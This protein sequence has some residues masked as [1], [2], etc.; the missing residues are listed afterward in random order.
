M[1]DKVNKII[2]SVFKI[3]RSKI[4]DSMEPKDVENCDSFS[5]LQLI[6]EIE[7]EFDVKFEIE[8]IFEIYCIG[9]IKRILAKKFN[10]ESKMGKPRVERFNNFSEI[11]N[12]W[13]EK[14]P[15]KIFIR[16][17][18]ANKKYT[19]ADFNSRVNA[20][21]RFLKQQGVEYGDI[22]D[23]TLKKVKHAEETGHPKE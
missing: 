17:V 13:A 18:S 16:D 3:D 12:H 10:K 8:E 5:G 2:E 6:S 15:T 9:D 19:Y 23:V 22:I 14:N 21:V 1:N 20:S 11:M 7:N 4:D